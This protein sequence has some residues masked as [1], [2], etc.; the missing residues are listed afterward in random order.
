MMRS[1]L[2]C[3]VGYWQSLVCFHVR[4]AHAARTGFVWRLARA[5]VHPAG[6]AGRKRARRNERGQHHERQHHN[7]N[8]ACDGGDY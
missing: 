7:R 2:I 3:G 4:Q 8:D 6:V 5:A 1:V